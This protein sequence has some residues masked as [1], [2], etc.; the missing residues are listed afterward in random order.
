MFRLLLASFLLC[1][2]LQVNSQQVVISSAQKKIVRTDSIIPA[3]INFSVIK[4]NAARITGLSYI[5]AHTGTEE[6]ANYTLGAFTFPAP[7]RP[8]SGSIAFSLSN[9]KDTP[10]VDKTII[11]RFKLELTDTTIFNF[12]T[13]T[14][15]H[16]KPS[17]PGAWQKD[18]S[19]KWKYE[20]NQ[21]TDFLGFD[22][23]RP[24]G[25]LQ[26]EVIL[27]FP[28]VK[29][30]LK[31][32]GIYFQPFRSVVFNALFNRIDKANNSQAY[33][34]GTTLP[35]DLAK[36]DSIRPYLT[37]LD[38]FKY[39]NLQF[40]LKFNV[41]TIHVDN[42]RMNFDYT[43]NVLR[44]KPYYS[45]TIKFAGATFTKDD[46]R[47]V[48]SF[49]QKIEMYL[50]T[51]KPIA[52]QINLAINAGLMFIQLKDSYYKQ[53]DA[54]VVDP[55]DKTTA[56][57]PANSALNSRRAK[58]IYFFSGTLEK[59]WGKE[60]KNAAFFRVNYFYQ[61]GSYQRYGGSTDLTQFDPKKF[62]TD[63]FHNHYLQL[64][65]GVSLDLNNFLG[66][67]DE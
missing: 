9:P 36:Q 11:L 21:F 2:F 10:G 37:T 65:L 23:Q 25:L 63:Q 54:A 52:G 56:L 49:A 58:P 47:P 46:L 27:K 55:F 12:D 19:N 15:L 29:N 30:R 16:A 4:C 7:S 5:D 44:N 31:A 64:Q 60:K 38:I 13:I 8:N 40:G 62:Y 22:N 59:L 45:D 66:I 67:K 35:N 34:L 14:L 28:I 26:Q 53:F 17:K 61:Q 1:F 50:N 33:P 48:Y 43:F 51:D 41:I 18:T 24:N 20:Y 39:S 32:G 6:S 42:I 57:L 3:A